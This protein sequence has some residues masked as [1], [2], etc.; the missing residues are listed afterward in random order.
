MVGTGARGCAASDAAAGVVGAVSDSGFPRFSCSS[1]SGQLFRPAPH[2]GAEPCAVP[3][4][5][6][7]SPSPQRKNDD[8]V[9]TAGRSV[10]VPVPSDP[11]AEQPA[12]LRVPGRKASAPTVIEVDD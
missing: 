9:H 2:R 5:G 10:V 12:A 3:G 4:D 7:S 6:N 8:I 1:C 11:L